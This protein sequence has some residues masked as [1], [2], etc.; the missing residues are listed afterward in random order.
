[1]RERCPTELG[2]M[3]KEE[4]QCRAPQLYQKLGEHTVLIPVA[5]GTKKPVRK[6]WQKTRFEETQTAK[7]QAELE[8]GN[9]GVLNGSPSGGLVDIDCDDDQFAEDFAAANQ[10][11]VAGTLQ[12]KGQ[13]G[14]HYWLK[15]TGEYPGGVSYIKD[16]AKLDAGEDKPEAGELRAGG[17]TVISGTH[18][19]G[20]EY[21]ILNDKPVAE[22]EFS[23]INWPEGYSYPEMKTADEQIAERVGAPFDD[24]PDLG[25]K[26]ASAFRC[27]T[28]TR[29][30][31]RDP[32]GQYAVADQLPP[33][34]RKLRAMPE[35][36]QDWLVPLRDDF[37]AL[38]IDIVNTGASTSPGLV[39]LVLNQLEYWQLRCQDRE[40]YLNEESVR[41]LSSHPENAP[42]RYGWHFKS[43]RRLAEEEL[44]SLYSESAV[45][46]AL[47]AIVRAGLA[48]VDPKP[49]NRK[50]VGRT[51]YYRLD[52]V[53]I[54]ERLLALGYDLARWAD[55]LNFDEIDRQRR[56]PSAPEAANVPDSA[57][58]GI[59]HGEE[60]VRHDAEPD[61]SSCPTMDGEPLIETPTKNPSLKFPSDGA[62]APEG[63]FSLSYYRENWK[64]LELQS[65]ELLP[66]ARDKKN[67]KKETERFVREAP[68]ARAFFLC[69]GG[70]VDW[71]D[72]VRRGFIQRF[73][74]GK[75]R[76][77][78]ILK[79]WTAREMGLTK[80]KRKVVDRDALDLWI[81][82][83]KR[84]TVELEYKLDESLR[85]GISCD[86]T[87][88]GEEASAAR[89]NVSNYREEL[90]EL[91]LF[92]VALGT[93]GAELEI[94]RGRWSCCPAS[95]IEPQ[96]VSLGIFERSNAGDVKLELKFR[97]AMIEAVASNHLLR[98]DIYRGL[99]GGRKIG[100]VAMDE[101][102][103]AT[104]KRRAELGTQLSLLRAVPSLVPRD[105]VEHWDQDCLEI[106]QSISH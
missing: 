59:R 56:E 53:A 96:I 105:V 81:E 18:P 47:K 12:T 36:K 82:N 84:E 46:K 62:D 104:E 70:E 25:F 54:R 90:K 57:E 87:H 49:P 41:F 95:S 97:T 19:S 34:A 93:K 80:W 100:G 35:S 86:P 75:I 102:E 85:Q 66:S 99:E 4:T 15:I 30:N 37:A 101:F 27:S 91:Y 39:A 69:L 2:V 17:F 55:H 13:R 76:F 52:L 42:R 106:R 71:N 103:S 43:A 78:E 32:V 22:I 63:D 5:A 8:A 72:G 40:D 21:Q 11:L 45:E 48:H 83:V 16:A 44:F 92:G 28:T 20:C 58:P 51:K 61:P 74:T 88:F 14:R 23:E 89:F 6:A 10:E 77:R 73:E 79:H 65:K 64:E 26:S 33:R 3:N 38:A 60:P 50:R 94:E 98:A 7:Y 1:M 67:T 68:I 29:R 24:R 31:A 9:I